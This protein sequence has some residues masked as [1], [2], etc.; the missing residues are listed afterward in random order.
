MYLSVGTLSNP[1]QFEA[2]LSVFIVIVV[3][4]NDPAELNGLTVMDVKMKT[5]LK[6]S[7]L[8]NIY[9]LIELWNV[10]VAEPI[11]LQ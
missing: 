2:F 10:Q 5:K 11:K 9:V 4:R 3:Y 1:L 7:I 6:Q 8:K